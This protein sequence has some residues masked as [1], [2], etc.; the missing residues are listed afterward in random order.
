MDTNNSMDNFFNINIDEEARQYL[1]TA[2]RWARVIAILSFIGTGISILSSVFRGA[3]I[4][5]AYT[6]S[7]LMGALIAGAIS[8]AMAV[9]LYRF[10]TNTYASL[11]NEK[12]EQFDAGIS[13]L[14]SYFKFFG[15]LLIVV[16][17]L[18]VL[19]GILFVLII[20]VRGFA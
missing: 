1:K 18:A 8:I 12:Q 16:L 6:V 14:R 2:C 4:G 15:I 20:S 10:A 9:L 13:N 17:S 7:N 5:M 3:R 11:S 19:A